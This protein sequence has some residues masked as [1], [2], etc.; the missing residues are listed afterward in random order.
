MDKMG[1]QSMNKKPFVLIEV[2]LSI[3]LLALCT[4]PFIVEPLFAQKKLRERFF[5]LELERVSETIYYEHLQKPL[6][7]SKI[8]RQKGQKWPLE[9]FSI[10]IEGF[11]TKRV[12]APHYHLYSLSKDK[13]ESPYYKIYL[14]I[15]FEKCLPKK[16]QFQFLGKVHDSE[17]NGLNPR[18]KEGASPN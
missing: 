15:C 11:G 7:L 10:T 9:P 5:N 14:S 13:H 18:M 1:H 8:T 2:I 4:F 3:S 16:H 6:P 12:K 17:F